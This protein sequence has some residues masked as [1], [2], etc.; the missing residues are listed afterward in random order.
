MAKRWTHGTKLEDIEGIGA[1]KARKL[2]KAGVASIAQLLEKGGTPEGRK[3]IAKATAIKPSLILEWV[4]HADLFR[5]IGVG[6]EY[7]DLLEEAGV[8]TV[9]ELSKRNPQALYAKLVE[10]NA[11]M[12]LVRKLPGRRQVGRWI[13]QAKRLPRRIKY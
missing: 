1:V 7:A 3:A 8:D 10:V 5:I 6:E 4:N 2:R 12:R 11:A 9:I 13:S